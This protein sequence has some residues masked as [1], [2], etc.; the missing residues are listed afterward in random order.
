LPYSA[1][2]A[3][4]APIAAELAYTLAPLAASGTAPFLS[5]CSGN[6]SHDASLREAADL[7]G[8]CQPQIFPHVQSFDRRRANAAR[9]CRAPASKTREL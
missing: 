7:V 8:L 2:T 4:V 6:R 3:P 1:I 5:M 9:R